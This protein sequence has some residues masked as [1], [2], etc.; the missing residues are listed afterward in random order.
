LQ[1]FQAGLG[2]GDEFFQPCLDLGVLGETRDFAQ[3]HDPS[4]Q[5]HFL[6]YQIVIGYPAIGL[7]LERERRICM[8]RCK[9]RC[10]IGKI[11]NFALHSAD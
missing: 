5:P 1:Q 4:S 9:N 11:F 10:E 2:V 3:A 8:A 7:T 6:I